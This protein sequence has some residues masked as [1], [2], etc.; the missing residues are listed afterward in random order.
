[1]RALVEMSHDSK[2][3]A[4]FHVKPL[5]AFDSAAERI[6]AYLQMFLGQEI[7]GEELEVVSGISEYARRVREWRVEFG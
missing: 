5:L 3:L 1:V 2:E 7:E 4:L 6:L